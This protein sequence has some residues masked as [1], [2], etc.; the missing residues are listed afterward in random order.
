MQAMQQQYLNIKR[1]CDRYSVGKSWIYQSIKEKIFPAPRKF[2]SNSRW[3]IQDLIQWE[4]DNGLLND[5][6][7]QD[8]GR[9]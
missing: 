6:G 9:E 1:V 2:G 8:Q 3:S 4:K 7:E 5:S